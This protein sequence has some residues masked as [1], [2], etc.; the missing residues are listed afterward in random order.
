MRLLHLHHDRPLAPPDASSLPP[1]P[2]TVMVAVAPTLLDLLPGLQA[3][4]GPGHA[5]EAGT[6][7][8]DGLALLRAPSTPTV[9]FWRARY[10]R[11]WL[12]VVDPGREADATSALN[13]GA[14]AYVGGAVSTVEVAAVLR[15]VNRRRDAALLPA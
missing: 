9:A 12:V 7:S 10:P 6:P 8:A 3:E 2:G 13:A 11:A 14:D 4:L 5:V 15:A 1:P